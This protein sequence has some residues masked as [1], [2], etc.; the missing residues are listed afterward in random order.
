MLHFAVNRPIG[1]IRSELQVRYRQPPDS[2]ISPNHMTTA[3]RDTASA[4]A[5]QLL[6]KTLSIGLP[7]FR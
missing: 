3:Q 2:S 1:A 4:V 7:D 5:G 6:A